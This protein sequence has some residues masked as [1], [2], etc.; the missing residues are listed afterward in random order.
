MAV[1]T[2]GDPNLWESVLEDLPLGASEELWLVSDRAELKGLGAPHVIVISNM[3]LLAISRPPMLSALIAA[4][5]ESLSIRSVARREVQLNL[6]GVG[7]HGRTLRLQWVDGPDDVTYAALQA[8]ILGQRPDF[9]RLEPWPRDFTLP[10]AYVG[11]HGCPVARQT[12]GALLFAP[13]RVCFVEENTRSCLWEVAA[14]DLTTV[15][16][17]GPGKWRRGGGFFGGGFGVLGAAEGMAIAAVLNSLTTRSGVMTIVHL[18][19]GADMSTWW[20]HADWHTPEDLQVELSWLVS[21]VRNG[22]AVEAEGGRD[23]VE[24]LAKLAE[25]HGAGALTDEEFAAAKARLMRGNPA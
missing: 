13:D 7:R 25:L 1:R 18:E 9:V 14:H 6:S 5:R 20:Q 10:T 16:F 21:A 11:G 15:E 17:G 24:R 12:V 22:K 3:Q 4:P 23:F 8:M 2:A 19:A